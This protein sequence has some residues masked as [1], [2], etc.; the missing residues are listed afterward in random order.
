MTDAQVVEWNNF[1]RQHLFAPIGG[2]KYRFICVMFD[3]PRTL[4]PQGLYDTLS[5][6]E[7]LGLQTIPNNVFLALATFKMLQ[8]EHILWIVEAFEDIKHNPDPA[9]RTRLWNEILITFENMKEWAVK[10]AADICAVCGGGW[11][12]E[13]FPCGHISCLTCAYAKSPCGICN[14]EGNGSEDSWG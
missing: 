6:L 11:A 8:L 12:D 13:P 10:R 3:L 5:K 4:S 7:F 9:E 14:Q 1:L 2:D